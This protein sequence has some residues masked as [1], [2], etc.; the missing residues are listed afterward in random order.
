MRATWIS[1]YF[2]EERK[3]NLGICCD[4]PFSWNIQVHRRRGS[5]SELLQ[6]EGLLEVGDV[7]LIHKNGNWKTVPFMFPEKD[8]WFYFHWNFYRLHGSLLSPYLIVP[9]LS[10]ENVMA[11][12][13]RPYRGY[14][15]IA[16]WLKS[17]LR[18]DPYSGN[19]CAIFRPLRWLTINWTD[20]E[21]SGHLGAVSGGDGNG[22]VI[23]D[24]LQ[25]GEESGAVIAEI[26]QNLGVRK[27]KREKKPFLLDN[28][29]YLMVLFSQ[30]TVTV[31]FSPIL[32]ISI[33]RR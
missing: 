22:D 2:E 25:H 27:G 14:P 16:F 24:I 5:G 15:F 26:K 21:D 32:S 33:E 13:D 10:A 31:S 18:L 20:E 11:L 9:L 28:Y 17:L 12:F 1:Q 8:L 30:D 23:G 6:D 19:Y 3:A 7:A 29:P 4:L